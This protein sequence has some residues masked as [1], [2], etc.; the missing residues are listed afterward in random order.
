MVDV[1]RVAGIAA[2]EA[3][4]AVLR[5]LVLGLGGL[6]DG[7]AYVGTADQ[8]LAG[9]REL[10][11]HDGSDVAFLD[12]EGFVEVAGVED[13]AGDV[14]TWVVTLLSR[15]TYMLW[16]SEATAR[17]MASMGLNTMRLQAKCSTVLM[18]GTVRG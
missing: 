5:V 18:T 12:V 1:A 6:G 11:V 3:D 13:V 16:S 15:L 9:G 10:D 2:P 17:F 8:L 7:V 4:G 14:R